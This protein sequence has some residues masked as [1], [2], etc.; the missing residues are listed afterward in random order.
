M[1]NTNATAD[2]S[3]CNGT[4]A[5][6]GHHKVCPDRDDDEQTRPVTT[7]SVRTLQHIRPHFVS[8]DLAHDA[9]DASLTYTSDDVVL[10]GLPP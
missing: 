5:I 3:S 4:S 7:I 10:F 1:H 6:L 2:L 9:Y 8:L